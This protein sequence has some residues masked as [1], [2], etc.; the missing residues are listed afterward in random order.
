MGA[1]PARPARIVLDANILVSA[2]IASGR[3]SGSVLGRTV[4]RAL[5]RRGHRHHVP[6]PLDRGVTGDRDL[7]VLQEVGIDV[8]TIGELAADLGAGR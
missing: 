4:D 3:A 2:V 7:L 5:W 1:A 8:I 6:A